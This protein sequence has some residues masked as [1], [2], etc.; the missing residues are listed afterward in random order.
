MSKE[1]LN[2]DEL[3]LRKYIQKKLNMTDEEFENTRAERIKVM[4]QQAGLSDRMN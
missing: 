1:Q 4:L 3:E 2:K